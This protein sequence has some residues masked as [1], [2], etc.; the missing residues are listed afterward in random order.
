MISLSLARRARRP[1][2]VPPAL[3]GNAP[4]AGALCATPLR[5]TP[6]AA[7][8]AK[9]T[10]RHASELS[11]PRA[12]PDHQRHG[13]SRPAPEDLARGGPSSCSC[14]PSLAHQVAVPTSRQSAKPP[15]PPAARDRHRGLPFRCISP[16][17]ADLTTV[18]EVPINLVTLCKA[19]TRVQS[20]RP[21]GSRK[22]KEVHHGA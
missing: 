2:C 11:P 7:C 15:S 17:P 4:G 1:A 14:A 5:A 19:S 20:P 12:P 21:S 8:P 18:Q 10:T 3:G 13:G 16:G 9:G 6:D 22:R